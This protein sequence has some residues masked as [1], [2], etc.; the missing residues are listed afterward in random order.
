MHKHGTK[1]E[2]C[3]STIV[4]EKKW[5]DTESLC[6]WKSESGWSSPLRNSLSFL[7]KNLNIKTIFEA[8]CGDFNWLKKFD[9]SGIDYTGWDIVDELLEKANSNK[10]SREI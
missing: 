7:A 8:G 2:G 6:G 4:K 1:H 9:F 3:F 5:G 10:G